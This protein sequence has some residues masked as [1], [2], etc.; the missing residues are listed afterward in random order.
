MTPSRTASS[1]PAGAGLVIVT[2]ASS[3]IGRALVELLARDGRPVLAVARGVD[4]LQVLARDTGAEMVAADVGVPGGRRDIVR[5]VGDRGVAALVHGA[6]IFPRG[7]LSSIGRQEFEVAMRTNL[8]ARL[9]LTLDLRRSLVGGRVLFVGS[10]AA[11]TP[12]EGGAVYSI[13]KAASAMLCRSLALELG[14]EIGFGLAR[15]GLVDTAMLEGS[16]AA[17]REDFPAGEVYEEMVERGEVIAPQTVARFF[18]WLLYETSK[19]EFA[20]DAW[21]IRD[22]AHHGHWLEGSLYRSLPD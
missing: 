12:R 17:S 21:D 20:S 8:E 13:S 3:G 14:G 7:L 9:W 19:S 16:R 6:G 2:G 5:A 22:R 11:R 18:S 4:R 10:D 1:A 15:P